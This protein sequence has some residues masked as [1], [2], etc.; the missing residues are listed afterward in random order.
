MWFRV[1][2]MGTG[3]PRGAAMNASRPPL[4]TVAQCGS[5]SLGE[6][7]AQQGGGV[8]FADAAVDLRPVMAGRT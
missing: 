6:E 3:D 8:L 1:P 2:E 4:P 5:P 7:A